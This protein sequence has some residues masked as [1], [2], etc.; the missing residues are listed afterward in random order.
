MVS[1]ISTRKAGDLPVRGERGGRRTTDDYV[2]PRRQGEHGV[3]R[4]K[5]TKD[6]STVRAAEKAD[7]YVSPRRHGEHGVTRRKTMR[8]GAAA[9]EDGSTP[10]ADGFLHSF[11]SAVSPFSVHLRVLRVLRVS[12]VRCSSSS[13]LGRSLHR[14][15]STAP[16]KGNLVVY[17]IVPRFR[18]TERTVL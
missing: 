4:R 13:V 15:R 6:G 12:V 5:A 14:R 7:D 17:C 10:R 2:S 3:T 1:A 18:T 11:P 16:E 9:G 8:G